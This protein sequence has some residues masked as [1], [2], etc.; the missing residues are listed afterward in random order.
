MASQFQLPVSYI[1]VPVLPPYERPIIVHKFWGL[2]GGQVMRSLSRV[3][4]ITIDVTLTDHETE[5]KLMEAIATMDTQVDEAEVASLWLRN[6]EYPQCIFKGFT[7]EGPA[8]KDPARQY[9]WT[10]KGKV[11][12]LQIRQEDPEP[13]TGT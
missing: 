7:P 6:I 9:G 5:T 2:I 3:R 10:Q 13:K 11:E 1:G 8:F 4:P 12:F